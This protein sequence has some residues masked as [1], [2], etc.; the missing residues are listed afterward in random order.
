MRRSATILLG[1]AL[2]LT[3][4]DA[5]AEAPEAT[6]TK[7]EVESIA[8]ELTPVAFVG[9]GSGPQVAV[10][11]A[12]IFRL[13]TVTWRRIYWTPLLIG[14][15]FAFAGTGQALYGMVGTAVGVPLRPWGPSGPMVR[16]EAGAGVGALAA[17]DD[18][19]FEDYGQNGAGYP[20]ALTAAARVEHQP[21]RGLVLGAGLRMVS[22]LPPHGDGG[23]IFILT[24]FSIGWVRAR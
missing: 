15:G 19:F 17:S 10:G 2:T 3:G 22:A 21:V 11:P 4:L 6:Q 23:A 7:P 9:G 13:M 24:S 16:L 1:A 8:L 5:Q 12:G 18:L 14:G 20:L